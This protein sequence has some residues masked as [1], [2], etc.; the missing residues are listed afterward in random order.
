MTT[1]E[2]MET[3]K[4]MPKGMIDTTLNRR[5]LRAAVGKTFT[6]QIALYSFLIRRVNGEEFAERYTVTITRERHGKSESYNKI[7]IPKREKDAMLRCIKE[8]AEIIE[9]Y[10]Q[11]F[12]VRGLLAGVA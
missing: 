4:A 1:T 7:V 11:S 2:T 9:E 8:N 12:Y 5:N 3:T 6:S 10:N